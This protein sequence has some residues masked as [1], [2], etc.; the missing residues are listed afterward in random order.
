MEKR[1][2][3]QTSPRVAPVSLGLQ[4][5]SQ[6]IGAGE[7]DLDLIDRDAHAPAVGQGCDQEPSPLIDLIAIPRED[8][9]LVLGKWRR[10]S[11]EPIAINARSRQ[12]RYRGAGGVGTELHT[13]HRLHEFVWNRTGLVARIGSV[14]ADRLGSNSGRRHDR[15]AREITRL[16]HLTRCR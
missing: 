15:L 4:S 7:T 5:G 1:P 6:W 8:D 12:N 9:L 3:A 16:A 11:L 10:L 14:G 13:G 2:V